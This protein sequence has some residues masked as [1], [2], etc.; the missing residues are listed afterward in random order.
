MEPDLNT[1]GEHSYQSWNA[2]DTPVLSR[3]E[4]SDQRW[5]FD[6]NQHYNLIEQFKDSR[7][8]THENF[9]NE[10]QIMNNYEQKTNFI[11]DL[12]PKRTRKLLAS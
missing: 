9:N 1:A 4:L 5:S 11:S 3:I 2:M 7:T 6:K 12:E 8:R 10:E